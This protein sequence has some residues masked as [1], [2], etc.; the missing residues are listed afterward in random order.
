MARDGEIVL[1]IVPVVEE[2]VPELTRV[3]TRAFDNDARKHLGVE[4]GGPAGY[5]DGEFF[6]KWLFS[7]DASVGYK[8]ASEGRMIGAF[9]LWLLEDGCN[10][11]GTIFVDPDYQDQGVGTRAW[12]F[13]EQTYPD[14]RRWTLATPGWAVKNHHFYE[15]KCGFTKIAEE[16]SQDGVSF[17]YQKTIRTK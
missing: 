8:I 12:R 15:R 13:I 16:V 1:E 2:D 6:R 9:I 14:S 10:R 7:Y 3:M 11:L 5:D 4:K 17:V